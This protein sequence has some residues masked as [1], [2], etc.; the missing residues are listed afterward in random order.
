MIKMLPEISPHVQEIFHMI[1]NLRHDSITCIRV[2][3]N[4]VEHARY[5]EVMSP[6]VS[7]YY[8][9]CNNGW[10]KSDCTGAY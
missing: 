8:F 1:D 2:T 3:L 7:T 9:N 10:I 4:N 5:Q 6:K